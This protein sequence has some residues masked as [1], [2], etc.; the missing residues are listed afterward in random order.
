MAREIMAFIL[1]VLAS[2]T[3]ATVVASFWIIREGSFRAD[4]LPGLWFM[5]TCLAAFC[6]MTFGIATFAY[7]ASQKWENALAYVAAGFIVGLIPGY[8]LIGR[9]KGIEALFICLSSGIPGAVCGL[10]WWLLARHHVGAG[11]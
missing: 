1:A 5:V 3:A 8:L 9:E 11:A 2:G 7:L 6:A 10:V 4:Q